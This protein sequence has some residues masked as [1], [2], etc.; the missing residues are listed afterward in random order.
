MQASIV[1]RLRK[2][3]VASAAIDQA[4]A[5][6]DDKPYAIATAAYAEVSQQ[7]HLEALA[8][9]A[10]LMEAGAAEAVILLEHLGG[11]P[12]VQAVIGA[13]VPEDT[14]GLDDSIGDELRRRIASALGRAYA[15]PSSVP[16]GAGRKLTI[17]AVAALRKVA[18]AGF[19]REDRGDAAILAAFRSGAPSVIELARELDRLGKVLPQRLPQSDFDA[20]QACFLATY[21]KIY[22]N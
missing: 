22:P 9:L 11:R 4:M 14:A 13:E 5:Q 1:A 10:V 18:R 12:A 8:A 6:L 16:E 3:S 2:R 20:D 17:E 19:R 15:D 21:R 7:L